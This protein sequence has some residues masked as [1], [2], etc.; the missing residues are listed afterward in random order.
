MNNQMFVLKIKRFALG[1]FVIST[2]GVVSRA[3]NANNI[4]AQE[5]STQTVTVASV[6][7]N[8][9]EGQEVILRGQI[10]SQQPE[11]TDYLFTDG[12]GKI[13]IQISENDFSY[14]PDTTVEIA[15]VVDFE[16]QHP[17]EVAQD[18]TPEDLQLN[19]NRLQIITPDN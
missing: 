6:L 18:P 12:T 3:A 4:V 10:I 7:D 8:P 16:S 1:L 19:V 5:S 14:N 9:V 11:E 2:L 15:G 17:D 13:T